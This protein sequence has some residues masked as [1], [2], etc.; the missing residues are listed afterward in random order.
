MPP[1]LYVTATGN[2]GFCIRFDSFVCAIDALWTIPAR[3]APGPPEVEL[4]RPDLV[5]ITHSHWDHFDPDAVLRA[6]TPHTAVL[7]PPD[8]IRRLA[9]IQTTTV[10]PAHGDGECPP[11]HAGP[12]TVTGYRTT[13]GR[14]H[15]SFLLEIGGF[16]LFHDGDNEDTRALP[17][18]PLSPLDVLM[19]CP[20]QGSGWV[21][22]VTSMS[23]RYWLLSHLSSGELAAHAAGRFLPELCDQVPLEER[24]V[25]LEPGETL[26]VQ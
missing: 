25:A 12:A 3:F 17:I 18:R 1:T 9:G 7:G 14:Q 24:I 8:V 6:A 16:R 21:E 22:F 15:V 4:P 2:A 5:V 23:P 10:W 20:W 11:V 26:R 13:H 19:L